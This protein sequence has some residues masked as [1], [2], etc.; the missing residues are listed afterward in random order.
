MIDVHDRA[1]GLAG[2]PRTEL[3]GCR[4]S[5][6]VLDQQIVALLAERVAL[7]Q[8]TAGLKRAAGLPILDPQREAEVIRRAVVAARA[9]NLPTETVRQIFWHIVGLSR[10]LQ[11]DAE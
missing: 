2:D 9:K 10:R 5:I 3:A 4:A 8:R 7:G 11:E 1:D 6:E